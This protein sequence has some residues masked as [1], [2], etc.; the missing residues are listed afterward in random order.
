MLTEADE[1]SKFAE[2]RH[3]FPLNMISNIT[4]FVLNIIVG[5]WYTPYLIAN[6]GVAVYGLVPLASSLTNYLSLLT[7]GFN[8]AVS[9]F[10]QIELAKEDVEAANRIFNTSVAGALTIFGSDYSHCNPGILICIGN[11]QCTPW[12]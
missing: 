9:R 2:A 4:W 7:D 10:L 6:L 8:S 11:L 12:S 1:K 3:Q 5:L